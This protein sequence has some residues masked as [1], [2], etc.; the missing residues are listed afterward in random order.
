[1]STAARQALFVRSCGERTVPGIWHENYW[2]RRHEIAYLYV[3][4]I[5]PAGL[6]VEAGSGEGYG[7]QILASHGADVVGIDYDE[8]AT[9]HQH[10]TYPHLGVVRGNL[11]A[12]PLRTS[13]VDA[14]VSMQTV[15]HLWDQDAFLVEAVR[16]TRRGGPVVVSTPNKLTFPAG[17]PHHPHELDPVELTSLMARHVGAVDLLSVRHGGRIREWER[18]HGSIVD[19]QL[20]CPPRLWDPELSELVRSVR[21]DDFVVDERRID[22]SLDLLAVAACP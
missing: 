5:L 15:E 18:R 10:R 21:A 12:L 2:F 6:V 19:R 1:M 3:A 20:A 14:F 9:A 11:V 4:P 8:Q 17:N 22:T 13:S 16:V 7:S